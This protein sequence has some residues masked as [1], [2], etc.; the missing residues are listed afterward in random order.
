MTIA[1]TRDMAVMINLARLVAVFTCHRDQ[2][3]AQLRYS[4][5]DITPGLKHWYNNAREL[6]FAL[7]KVANIALEYAASALGHD[8]TERLHQPTDL[9]RYLQTHLEKLV[10]RC[11]QRA[12]QHAIEP[13]H[14]NLS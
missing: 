9:V 2:L 8:E 13:F 6:L 12:D 3:L 11:N 7:E 5:S 14:P 10:P 1:T 4:I